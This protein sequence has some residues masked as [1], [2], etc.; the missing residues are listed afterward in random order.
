MR[1]KF[2]NKALVQ[3]IYK[4]KVNQ[5]RKGL[6]LR[7]PSITRANAWGHSAWNLLHDNQDT[8]NAD[9]NPAQLYKNAG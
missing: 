8:A 1:G 2:S 5:N 4:I 9:L 3:I 7:Q 6:Q